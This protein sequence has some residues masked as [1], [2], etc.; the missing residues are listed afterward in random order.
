MSIGQYTL[1]SQNEAGVKPR[2]CGETIWWGQDQEHWDGSRLVTKM[3]FS[4]MYT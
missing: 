3:L 1:E 2:V 4:L